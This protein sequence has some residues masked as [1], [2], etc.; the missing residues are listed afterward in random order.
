MARA[1][2][3][4]LVASRRARTTVARTPQ[5]RATHM[6]V[7]RVVTARAMLVAVG[8]SRTHDRAAISTAE[9]SAHDEAAHYLLTRKKKGRGF[10]RPFL[11]ASLKRVSGQ[12]FR[13][14]SRSALP[15]CGSR[16]DLHKTHDCPGDS[17]LHWSWT[18]SRAAGSLQHAMEDEPL[19]LLGNTLAG[20]LA[21]GIR[22]RC[23]SL[24]L[25]CVRLWLRP[26]RVPL[27]KL[28]RFARYPLCGI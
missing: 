12:G 17:G 8:V 20:I 27:L 10:P 1:P 21:P 15:V 6:R 24:G 28:A 9:R 5:H 4:P 25:F 16:V 22:I 11:W 18:A 2:A 3:V 7:R 14:G 19:M 23:R 26:W 13:L